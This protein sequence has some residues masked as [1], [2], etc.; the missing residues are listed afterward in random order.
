[1][2]HPGVLKIFEYFIDTERLYIVTE[3]IAGG[4]LLKEMNKRKGTKQP[5]FTEE[6]AALMIKQ[7]LTVLNYIHMKNIIHRDVKPENI[8]IE[9]MPSLNEPDIPW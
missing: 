5:H 4:E 8:M 6:E 9:S 7:V 1:M 3:F 2:D